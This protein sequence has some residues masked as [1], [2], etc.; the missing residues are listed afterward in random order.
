MLRTKFF[1]GMTPRVNGD[2]YVIFATGQTTTLK[3]SLPDGVV[4]AGPT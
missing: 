4:Q 3:Y 2:A 1:W